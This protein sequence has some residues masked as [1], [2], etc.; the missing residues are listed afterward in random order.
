[1][2]SFTGDTVRSK[3]GELVMTAKNTTEPAKTAAYLKKHAH[4]RVVMIVKSKTP[5]L[6]IA[7]AITYFGEHGLVLM[8]KSGKPT[9]QKISVQIPENWTAKKSYYVDKIVEEQST[10]DIGPIGQK[11][12]G[13]ALF[14]NFGGLAINRGFIVVQAAIA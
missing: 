1:V 2:E 11:P 12:N 4:E 14:P 13:A 8:F 6:T 9:W 10:K 3:I 5:G 7:Q